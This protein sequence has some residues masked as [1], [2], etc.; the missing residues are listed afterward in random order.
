VP[1]GTYALSEE[2]PFNDVERGRSL[3]RVLG[4][5]L[6]AVV[7]EPVIEGPPAAAWL[8][9]L[10]EE[11]ERCGALLV[12]DEIKTGFRL[13]VGGAAER[14]RIAPDLVVFG[15]ALANGFPLAAVGGRRE[16][17]EAARQTWISSTLA[18]EM[19]ALAAAE[20]ALAAVVDLGVPAHLAR[21]GQ[22]FVDGLGRLASRY[23][24]L[25]SGVAGLPEMC[26][27]RFTS[28][29]A[30]IRVAREA[31]GQGLLF[32]RTAYNFVSLAHDA[33]SVER[34]LG[35]LEQVCEEIGG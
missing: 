5:R 32:K 20:A 9:M 27:L 18:T 35:I 10:R 15:K 8:A 14:Y 13:A 4:D 1:A 34:G 12:L 17:M 11:T 21:V 26:F 29:E 22:S 24:N 3:I 6:A 28:E 33:A 31:A 2:I 7:I 25:I 19:V 23:P 30:G 16:A